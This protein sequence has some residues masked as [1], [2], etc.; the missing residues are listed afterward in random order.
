MPNDNLVRAILEL[1]LEH[2]KLDA[3]LNE[4]VKQFGKVSDAIDTQ[5]KSLQ[6]LID[7]EAKLID[8][9]NKS[10]NPTNIA[11]YNAKITETQ[12]QIKQLQAATKAETKEVEGLGKALKNAFTTTQLNAMR[13]E[14][15]ALGVEFSSVSSGAKQFLKDTSNGVV[16]TTNAFTKL[17]AEIKIAKGELA[18][19]FSSG[20]QEAI[21]KA[22]EK[23]DD[24][25]DN[26]KSLSQTGS[27]LERLPVLF[28]DITKNIL[29]LD[30]SR[31]NAQSKQL[32]ATT[33][34]ITFA[35]AGK[36]LLDLGGTL[37]N[38]GKSLLLNPI[39][40]IAGTVIAIIAN[41]DKLKASGGALGTTF[42]FIGD[43]IDG[44]KTG[45]FNLTDAIGLTTHALDEFNEKKLEGLKKQSEEDTKALDR[46]TKIFKAQGK[47]TE[48]IE[49]RKLELISASAK[50]QVKVFDEIAKAHG[51]LTEEQIK[52]R[53]EAFEADNDAIADL[54]VLEGE[55]RKKRIDE[56]KN[57][58]K[59]LIDIEK[60]LR[61]EQA[62][63]QEFTIRNTFAD[64]SKAQIEQTF[65]LRGQLEKEALAETE[66]NALKDLNSKSDR[67]KAKALIT[68]I[69]IQQEL[70]LENDKNLAIVNLDNETSKASLERANQ[71]TLLLLAQSEDS[72][73]GIARQ[74]LLIQEDY[75]TKALKL[76]EDDITKRKALGFDTTSQEKALLDLKLKAQS[77]NFK[78]IEDLNKQETDLAVK[79]N[80]LKE[81]QANT[82]LKLQ[83]SR[84]STELDSELKFEQDKLAILE[85][86]GKAY[87][88]EAKRQADKVALLEKE[89]I[90][91]RRLENIS[92]YEQ[93]SQAAISATNQIL[94]TK[95]KEIDQQS[96]LQQKRVD[97]AKGI[98]DQGNAE[99]LELEKER[100]DNLHKEKEKFVRAQQA[101][102]AIELI[103][104]TAIAVSKAAAEG[105]A[106]AGITIAAA[107]LAL[108]AGLA[109]AR[110]I[111]SQAAFYDGGYTG[112]GNPR[113]VSR[114]LGP[115]NYT[116][117]KGEFVF[118]HEKTGKYRD[119]FQGIHQGKIDLGDWH[120]KVMSFDYLT[121]LNSMNTQVPMFM[122]PQV[123]NNTV[124]IR[125]L[126]G[127]MDLLI[128]VVKGQKT[129]IHFDKHGFWGSLKGVM[130]RDN[131][132]KDN[133]K[134]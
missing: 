93:I 108:V 6:K 12:N 11:K 49:K 114:A 123:V 46:L 48:D 131:F 94:D 129:D 55:A 113:D 2:S 44:L 88:D 13:K 4:T 121:K 99:L 64:A 106:A 32:L 133:A 39:F 53:H 119:I 60:Q 38:L 57:A 20:N 134:A 89:A 24:L 103:S 27:K 77:D 85:A 95:I 132:L 1:D 51:G 97:E 45:F 9:R 84:H 96:Q 29:S 87:A 98:A 74:K 120:N 116:Y 10:N 52:Q 8:A 14:L 128:Q 63:T 56:A 112:D 22:A 40:L 102:A 43:V 81:S 111:A 130:D 35:E 3:G 115:K 61:I 16:T 41:F 122:P 76:A 34:S 58:S 65:K 36:G 82:Q 19:A 79:Q 118:D 47:S 91:Q 25:K 126:K 75:Y 101:L 71:N 107:L 5:K 59:I 117:H 90:K 109:S 18:E 73:I 21:T 70:N 92:Y 104:N 42:R 80:E 67:E 15:K 7:D 105:G 78:A 110:S 86:G 31:A 127:Q 72:E 37:L 28:G 125:E 124:E 62:K 30:F 26:L 54:L 50:K 33:K 69:R 17:K 100:L 23:V 66:K 68:K 83:N